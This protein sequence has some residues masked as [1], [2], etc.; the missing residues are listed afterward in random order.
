MS[1]ARRW[2]V[3]ALWQRPHLAREITVVLMIKTLLLVLICKLAAPGPAGRRVDAGLAAQHLL[4]SGPR[5][6]PLEHGHGR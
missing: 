1:C 6:E 2:L 4:G 5:A 3:R